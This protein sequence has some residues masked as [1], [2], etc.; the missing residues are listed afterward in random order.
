[1]LAEFFFQPFDKCY[2]GCTPDMDQDTTFCG[3]LSS[4]YV[5]SEALAAN[6][7]ASIHQLG[8][9]YKVGFK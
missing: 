3:Q 5:F 1:M 9:A 6:Y 4:I 7:I 2:I 8:P